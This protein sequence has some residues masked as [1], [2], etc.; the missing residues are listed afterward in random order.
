MK[1][2]STAFAT[3]DGRHARHPP[4]NVCR[5]FDLHEA[6]GAVCITMEY[7]PGKDHKN[8]LRM[9]G[10]FTIGKEVSVAE[11]VCEGLKEVQQR[12]IFHRDL[13]SENIIL[14]RDGNARIMDFD[15]DSFLETK[16]LTAERIAIGTPTYMSPEQSAGKIIDQAIG[17]LLPGS[18]HIR[19]GDR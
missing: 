4:R 15:I 16:G 13:K 8:S 12:R 17:H 14:D 18:Y 10:P 9:M 7:V 19:D 1:R 11:Q 6:E 3:N 2:T 5:M